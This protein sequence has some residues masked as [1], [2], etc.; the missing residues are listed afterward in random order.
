[1]ETKPRSPI[2]VLISDVNYNLQTLELA[3]AAMR[4]AID[5]SNKLRVPLI[6]AGDLHDTKASM[7]AECVNAM[8]ETFKTPVKYGCY[9]MVGNHDKINEKSSAHSLNFLAPFVTIISDPV[10]VHLFGVN[11]TYLVPYYHDISLLKGYL[12]EL[13]NGSTVIMHQGLDGSDSGDYY[14]DPTALTWK[15]V[16]HL[17]VISGHYHRRQTIHTGTSSTFTYIGNPYALGFGEANHPEKGFQILM[18]DGTLEFVPTNLRKHIIYECD[19]ESPLSMAA[20]PKNRPEDL[21][22]IKAKGN[23][24]THGKDLKAYVAG[25][26]GIE[27][28]FR[29]EH[30]TEEQHSMRELLESFIQPSQEELLDS[31][32]DSLSNTPDD[33]K[34]QLKAMWKALK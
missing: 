26:A 11:F 2:A 19:A 14:Q 32:I 1:M 27:G 22:W 13:K 33:K 18:N 28:D 3:D 24:N 17:N 23:P 6:V 9:V 25:Y 34:A 31:L 7:R 15:D 10:R 29:F 30:I 8:L 16:H 20:C 21:L 4:L 12:R 5:K